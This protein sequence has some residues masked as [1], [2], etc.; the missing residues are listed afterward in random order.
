MT[1]T[2]NTA[3]AAASETELLLLIEQQPPLA[4]DAAAAPK[5]PLAKPLVHGKSPF[6]RLERSTT[7]RT[8]RMGPAFSSSTT[9]QVYP[10]EDS[11]IAA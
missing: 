4:E 3:A 9:R 5:Q 11:A 6:A 7:C 10:D 1:K 8:K 2:E